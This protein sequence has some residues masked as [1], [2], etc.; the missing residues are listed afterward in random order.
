[1]QQASHI[2]WIGLATFIA[3]LGGFL[4]VL[5]GLGLQIAGFIRS[6]KQLTLSQS[7]SIKLETVHKQVNGNTERLLNIVEKAQET[8]K[9]TAVVSAAALQDAKDKTN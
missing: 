3:A 2:D 5:G 9:A 8:A 7:N 6:G 4:T 1:M